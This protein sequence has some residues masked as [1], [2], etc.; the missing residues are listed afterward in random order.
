LA[1]AGVG[2]DVALQVVHGVAAVHEQP[3][4]GDR[5][6]GQLQEGLDVAP[7]HVWVGAQAWP[8]LPQLP[9]SVVG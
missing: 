4:E 7:L 3:D 9:A 6:D 2:V 8:Q 1:H 5:N